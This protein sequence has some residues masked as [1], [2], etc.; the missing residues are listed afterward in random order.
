MLEH[1]YR[2]SL[3]V[4]AVTGII[5]TGYYAACVIGMV[6]DWALFLRGPRR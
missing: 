3:V 5:M 1:A 2:V 4:L 6:V